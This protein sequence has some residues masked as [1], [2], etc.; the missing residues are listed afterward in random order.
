MER[1]EVVRAA[2]DVHGYG[3]SH[4]RGADESQDGCGG[5]LPSERV[6]SED[7]EEEGAEHEVEG[8]DDVDVEGG[9]VRVVSEKAVVLRVEVKRS[10]KIC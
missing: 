5:A 9:I 6:D 3:G 8:E 2:H 7:E 4:A 1:D 10:E